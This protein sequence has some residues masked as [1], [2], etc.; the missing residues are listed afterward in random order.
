M[1]QFRA[2]PA[3]GILYLV[4][5]IR[6]AGSPAMHRGTVV[7]EAIGRLLTGAVEHDLSQLKHEAVDKYRLLIKNDPENYNGA[8]VEQELRVLLRCLEIC[9]PLMSAWEKPLA[10]Q[11]EILLELEDIEV[12]VLGFI[13]L[14]YPSEVRELKST[15]KPK[16][17]IARDHAFQVATY[18]LAI[19]RETGEWPVACV[20]Y[21]TPDSLHSFAL[22]N[23]EMEAREVIKTARQIRT[24]LSEAKDKE[25]LRRSI[26]PD[27]KQW[28]W[29]YRPRSKLA[30]VDFFSL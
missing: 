3:L 4:L 14:L 9:V 19:Q 23:V 8:Y 2:D 22:E 10:Y 12:P 13:D 16:R 21:I 11:K 17:E 30:A 25:S 26:R 28:I 6:E 1:L 5:G 24:L 27:F 20:D 18:A 29:R 7:D 15:V